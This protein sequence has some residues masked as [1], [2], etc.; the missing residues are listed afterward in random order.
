MD[1]ETHKKLRER[2]F[3]LQVGTKW[4]YSY[5]LWYGDTYLGNI[6]RWAYSSDNRSEADAML[7]PCNRVQLTLLS[8]LVEFA[9]QRPAYELL[10][11]LAREIF[12]AWQ[13]TL[14]GTPDQMAAF[15]AFGEQMLNKM[16]V[17]RRAIQQV[18]EVAE[19]QVRYD[20]EDG[21]EEE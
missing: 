14:M 15:A 1:Q 13:T 17:L 8:T 9:N 21:D 18:D 19:V 12:A 6:G 20:A 16:E 2:E 5:S 4:P 3:W 10:E 11:R 7:F